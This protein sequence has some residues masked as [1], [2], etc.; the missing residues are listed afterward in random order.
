MKQC[1][2]ELQAAGYDLPLLIP[3]GSPHNVYDESNSKRVH[4]G[5]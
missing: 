4:A 3:W 2:I 5:V 1:F